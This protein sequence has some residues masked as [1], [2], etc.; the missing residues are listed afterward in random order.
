MSSFILT[1]ALSALKDP[2]LECQ[3]AYEDYRRRHLFSKWQSLLVRLLINKSSKP[4]K[5]FRNLALLNSLELVSDFVNK[6]PLIF[7]RITPAINNLS[8]SCLG[9][10]VFNR[11]PLRLGVK[12]RH[13]RHSLSLNRQCEKTHS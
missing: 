12:Y 13:F 10:C 6:F 4:C 9:L 3:T 5:I 2:F 1:D 7:Q 11:I 8:K